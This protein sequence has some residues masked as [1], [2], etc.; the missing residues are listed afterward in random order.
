MKICRMKQW[1]S[2]YFPDGGVWGKKLYDKICAKNCMKMKA[3]GPGGRGGALAPP[4]GS[5]NVKN[6]SFILY[7]VVSQFW[8]F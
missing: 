7:F 6:R 8:I 2:Q 1:R 5:A 4:L 3:I